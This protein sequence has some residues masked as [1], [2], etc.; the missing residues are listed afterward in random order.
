M[1]PDSETTFLG[2]VSGGDF[3][4]AFEFQTQ[5]SFITEEYTIFARVAFLKTKRHC[6]LNHPKKGVRV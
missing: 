5:I 6:L 2:T 1:F 3:L 4:G